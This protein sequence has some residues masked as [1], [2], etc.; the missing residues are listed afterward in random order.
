MSDFF[1]A[2]ALGIVLAN[3][4]TIVVLVNKFIGE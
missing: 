3:L 2:V 1:W 4:S